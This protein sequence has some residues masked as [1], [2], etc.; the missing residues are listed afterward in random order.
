MI[1]GKVW[2]TT[3][4]I[5]KNS[6]FEV[7][8]ICAKAGGYCSE[9]YHDM[10]YNMFWIESGEMKIS[11]FNGDLVDV[12]VIKDGMSTIVPPNIWH[13]FEAVKDTI[14]Y[15]IYWV[16]LPVLDIVRRTTGGLKDGPI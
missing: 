11:R 16:E 9:H 15:E 6:I 3:E 5:H 14:A 8:R 7:H 1:E 4:C 12:T 2:G 10:K 13:M